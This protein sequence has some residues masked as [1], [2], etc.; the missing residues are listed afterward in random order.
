MEFLGTADVPAF[1]LTYRTATHERGSVD[2]RLVV[3][4]LF[5]AA[6]PAELDALFVTSDLQGHVVAD[7]KQMLLGF[8]AADAVAAYCAS[9][10]I[11]RERVGV[12][13]AGDLFAFDDL[14]RRGG[15][16]DVRPVWRAFAARAAFVVGVAGNHDAFGRTPADLLA[17]GQEPGVHLLDAGTPGL[18]ASVECGGL[19]I[20]GVSGI[21]GNPARAWRKTPDDFLEAVAAAIATRPDVLLLHQNPALPGVRRDEMTRLTQLL[22]AAGRGLVVFGHAYSPNPRTTL[23]RCQV[24]ATEGRAF[25]IERSA[26]VG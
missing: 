11:A 9:R 1:S 4:R 5:A 19:R 25:W 24:L 14:E 10:G 23:G 22:A 18:P 17:F 8:A 16:G 15:L 21:V 3:E 12:L 20:A 26:P 13:L 6:L 7:G 2:V